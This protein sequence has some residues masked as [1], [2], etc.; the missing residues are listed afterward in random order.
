MLNKI[1]SKY[2]LMF[3]QIQ[4]DI[5]V[6]IYINIKKDYVKSYNIKL[7]ILI[8]KY[9]YFVNVQILSKN[10]QDLFIDVVVLVVVVVDFVDKSLE[11]FFI[12]LKNYFCILNK[13]K[14]LY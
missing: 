8:L 6:K 4:V 3:F 13:N 9:G 10:Q 1:L 5:F 12:L 2:I 7:Y 14:K 11:K